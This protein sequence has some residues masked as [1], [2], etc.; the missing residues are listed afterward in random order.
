[1]F[2]EVREIARN[3]CG[4]KGA[5]WSRVIGD[6]PVTPELDSE[7]LVHN[8]ALIHKYTLVGQEDYL[9]VV[10]CHSIVVISKEDLAEYALYT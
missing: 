2:A 7:A 10:R 4:Q 5:N 3:V 9:E 8:Q 1:M 6:G